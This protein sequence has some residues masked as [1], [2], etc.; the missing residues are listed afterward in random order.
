MFIRDLFEDFG[1]IVPKVSFLLDL[2]LE[3][4]S[5]T[6]G[7]D[8]FHGGFLDGSFYPRSS[9]V[10]VTHRVYPFPRNSIAGFRWSPRTAPEQILHRS[11]RTLMKPDKNEE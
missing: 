2:L 6:A 7:K 10:S 4:F 9:E 8:G 5:E 3:R 1:K 11:D